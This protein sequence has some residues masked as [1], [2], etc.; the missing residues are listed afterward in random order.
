[1]RGASISCKMLARLLCV[2][3]G[4]G[5]GMGS[6]ERVVGGQAVGRQIGTAVQPELLAPL[7]W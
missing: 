2:K 6:K 4:E 7:I 3:Q 5:D 1:M